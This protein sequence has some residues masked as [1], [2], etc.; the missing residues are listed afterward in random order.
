[1]RHRDRRGPGGLATAM[2]LGAKGYRVTVVDRLDRPAGAGLDHQGRAPLRPWP[3][4]RHRAAG[5]ARPLG[6]LRPR[7]PRRRGSA[8]DG[9][10]LRDPVRRRRNA[11]PRTD[12]AA[13]EAEVA[14]AVA[15]RPARL[16]AVPDRCARRRYSF[17]F[18]DLGR[19]PMHKLMDLIKVLPKFV[20]CAPTNRFMPTPQPGSRT[21]ACA[22]RC[23]SI[24]CSSAAIRSTSPR[25]NPGQPSGD[26]T[27][28]ST[29]PWAGCRRLPTPW[30]A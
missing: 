27:L 18:E 28:A 19:R 30:S 4:D 5:P 1:M 13:M 7:F 20:C 16:R 24:R 22:L 10:V 3:D 9:P 29:T 26:M 6:R 25:C 2:R 15:R 21:N 23:R 14:R 17:G 11:S 8:P 12:T